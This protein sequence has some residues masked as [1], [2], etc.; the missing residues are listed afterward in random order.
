MVMDFAHL[1][2]FHSSFWVAFRVKCLCLVLLVGYQAV[3]GVI[4][5]CKGIGKQSFEWCRQEFVDLS[6]SAHRQ[7]KSGGFS[8]NGSAIFMWHVGSKRR[9][10]QRER[11]FIMLIEGKMS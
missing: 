3:F 8:P 2:T 7:K 6:R 1:M 10:I 4:T 11:V 5:H 9:L